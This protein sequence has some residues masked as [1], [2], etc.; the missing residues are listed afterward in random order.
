MFIGYGA[1][2]NRTPYMV[3]G[4][5]TGD[6]SS[7]YSLVG[8]K[9]NLGTGIITKDAD[10]FHLGFC[11][12]ADVYH[13]I[14]F[15][16]STSGSSDNSYLSI[17][18]PTKFVDSEKPITFQG[19]A[20]F[21]NSVDLCNT[22]IFYAQDNTTKKMIIADDTTFNTGVTF[23]GNATFNTNVSLDGTTNTVGTNLTISNGVRPFPAG[24]PISPRIP[25]IDFIIAI[26]PVLLL[27]RK[28]LDIHL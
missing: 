27:F 26:F 14:S 12:K 11:S 18:A 28:M 6:K 16:D 1:D 20:T 15:V 7:K 25:E 4:A 13:S 3:F 5:G 10:G 19:V 21:N 2:A 23:N 22:V 9:L 17:N 8:H 24:P